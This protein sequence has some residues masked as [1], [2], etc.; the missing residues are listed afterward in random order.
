MSSPYENHVWVY[1]TQ[2]DLYGTATCLLFD[3]HAQASRIIGVPLFYFP[4]ET[5]GFYWESE[6]FSHAPKFVLK[7]DI[8]VNDWNGK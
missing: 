2:T 4:D 3:D 5:G 8:T 7:G 1:D 6:Y